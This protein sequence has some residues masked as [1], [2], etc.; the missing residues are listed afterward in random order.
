VITWLV[1]SGSAPKPEPDHRGDE[2]IGLGIEELT[3]LVT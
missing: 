1:E 2:S 3:N